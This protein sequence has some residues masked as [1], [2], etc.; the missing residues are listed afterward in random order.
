MHVPTAL[1]RLVLGAGLC[2]ARVS[3][4]SRGQIVFQTYAVSRHVLLTLDRLR[5]QP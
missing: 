3:V 5:Y 1:S 2:A 4:S